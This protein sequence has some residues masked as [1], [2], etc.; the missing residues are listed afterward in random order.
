[1]KNT[2]PDKREGT[3]TICKS[4]LAGNSLP[5]AAPCTH[6]MSV[7]DTSLAGTIHLYHPP[8]IATRIKTHPLPTCLLGQD[9]PA[10]TV[11]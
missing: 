10:N 9:T 7:A 8:K 5:H 4:C 6:K 3:A 2:F 11:C 1:M